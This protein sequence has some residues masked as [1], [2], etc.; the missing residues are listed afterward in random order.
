[1]APKIKRKKN[2]PTMLGKTIL[3]IVHE[4]AEGLHRVGGIDTITMREFD[5]LCLPPVH[6]MTPKQI[7]KLR[8]REKMSQP[9][10]ASLLNISPSIV[11]QWEQGT[12]RPRGSSLRLLNLVAEQGL[13]IFMP[14][15]R[16][17]N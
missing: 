3:E 11:K 1:M 8:E 4:M 14:Q 7:K 6:E 10:F 5:M 15:H 12:K 16:T 2:E 13:S 9:V 17:S